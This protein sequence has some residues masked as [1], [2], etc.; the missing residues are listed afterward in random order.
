ML[1]EINILGIFFAP[2]AGY[3]VVAFLIFYPLRMLFDRWALHRYVWHRPLFDI[4][5]YVIILSIIGLIIT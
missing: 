1:K 2:F 3:V 5:V 4:S